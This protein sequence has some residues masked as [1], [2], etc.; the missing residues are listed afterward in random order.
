[1]MVGFVSWES[2]S[3]IHIK[4]TNNIDVFLT[5]MEFLNTTWFSSRRKREFFQYKWFSSQGWHEHIKQLCLAFV[6]IG[7][8]EWMCKILLSQLLNPI[9]N[10][11]SDCNQLLLSPRLTMEKS[12]LDLQANIFTKMKEK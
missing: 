2:V 9:I 3:N 12:L 7:R 4:G 5:N 10:S 11:D 1:M 6:K 8:P